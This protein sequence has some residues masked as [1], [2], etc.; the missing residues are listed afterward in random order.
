MKL[1]VIYPHPNLDTIPSLVAVIEM[2][3]R[4]GHDVD[5]YT[6][7]GADHPTPS[8]SAADRVRL[9]PIGRD[10]S[11]DL[12][13][14]TANVRALVKRRGWLP[15]A[16]RGPLGR[17]YRALG[18]G[19]QHGSRLATRARGALRA[20][21]AAT[22]YDYVIGVDPDGL[23]LAAGLAAGAPLVYYSLE[24][25]LSDEI[26]S[27]AEAAIKARERQLSERAALVIVQD[28]D[29]GRLLADDNNIPMD[30]LALLPNAPPGPARRQRTRYWHDHFGLAPDVQ[31]VL[32]SGS[33]GDWTGIESIVESVSAWPDNW[34]LV[35]HTRYDAESSGYVDRLRATADP[36]RVFFSLRPVPRQDYDALIDG[37]DI[38]LAFYVPSDNSSF[39]Q[40]NVQTIGL[41][42]GKLA[43]YLRAGLPVI[44]NRATALGDV[45]ESAGCGV[46]VED[47]GSIPRA[48]ELIEPRWEAYS[49]AACAFFAEHLDIERAFATVLDRMTA[50]SGVA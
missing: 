1:A 23:E 7:V 17:G 27:P 2:L 45:M 30:R 43:Y 20:P 39:T 6:A 10:T 41:S 36:R 46:A 19:L 3:A 28:A 12:D 38:G 47:A 49:D 9:R 29:R 18:Q 26:S 37:A 24:L 35:V 48:L 21:G 33:L 15:G 34:V 44:V 31:V 13:R 50:L 11:A 32:H 40:R 14:A 5:V 4:A 16:V 25:L 8:F 22:A 42:S